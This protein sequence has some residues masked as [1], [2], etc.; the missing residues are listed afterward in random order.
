MKVVQLSLNLF[1]EPS[2]EEGIDRIASS[3]L[4]II[5]TKRLR[6]S[7]SMIIQHDNQRV[8]KLPHSLREAPASVKESLINWACLKRPHLKRNRKEYLNHKK[9]LE[10]SIWSYLLQQ[11]THLH[12][13]I[14]NP[15]KFIHTTQGGKYD[16]QVMFSTL[17]QDYFNNS[18]SSYIRW[19]SALSKTSFQSMYR[20][21]HGSL[22]SLITIA[23]IYDHPLIPQFALMSLVHHEML[24]IAIPPYKKNGRTIMHGLEFKKAEKA[25]TMYDQW[26][27]W[28]KKE[29]P[30][31]LPEILRQKKKALR[32]C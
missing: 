29:L 3:N 32:S 26:H 28:E 7:W 25:F 23:G 14:K 1:Q 12:H 18:I 13:T 16:L 22:F 30:K 11:G 31:L 27:Q 17:N 2:L 19:G 10:K 21:S 8:L 20:D 4:T 15:Q 6:K 24:H 5:Y 9:N